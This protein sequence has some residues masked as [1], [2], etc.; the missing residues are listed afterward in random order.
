MTPKGA[1]MD[2]AVSGIGCP[3]CRWSA[4]VVRRAV[5]Q[6]G[7]SVGGNGVNERFDGRL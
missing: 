2:I 1:P 3:G 4:D 5:E 6:A 7:V